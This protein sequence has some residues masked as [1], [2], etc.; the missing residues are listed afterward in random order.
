MTARR[1][2]IMANKNLVNRTQIGSAIDSKLYAQLK[3]Y[4]FKSGVP[5]SKLLDRSVKMY[6]DS[7]SDKKNLL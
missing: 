6:L 1:V 7:I 2:I 4:S 5:I 3:E